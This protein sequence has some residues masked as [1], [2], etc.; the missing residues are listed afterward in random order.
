WDGTMYDGGKVD[1]SWDNIWFSQVRNYEDRWIFEMAVPFKTIRYKHGEKVW[2]VNFSRLDLKAAEKSSWTPISRQ[3]PSASQAHT[4]N[5]VWD[6]PALAAQSNVSIMPNAFGGVR[7]D[8]ENG[9][10][11]SARPDVGVDAKVAL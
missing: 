5:L 7:R 1:V 2:G 3:L 11:P 8:H 10:A 4:G 6:Q 9:T